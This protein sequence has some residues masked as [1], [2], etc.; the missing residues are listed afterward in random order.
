MYNPSTEGLRRALHHLKN[1]EE[2]VNAIQLALRN[3]ADTVTLNRHVEAIEMCLV[4][5]ANNIAAVL[6]NELIK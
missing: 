3:G 6:E 4:S 1:A 2:N 5:A